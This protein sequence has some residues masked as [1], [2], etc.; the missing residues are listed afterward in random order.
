MSIFLDEAKINIKAGDGGPGIVSF[1]FLKGSHKKIACGGNGGKGGNVVFK[2]SGSVATLYGFKKKVHYKAENG[3]AG[4]PNNRQGKRG[5]DCFINVPAGTVIKNDGEICADLIREGQEYLAEEGGIGGR[6]NASFVSQQRRFPGFAEKG[7]KVC[8]RWINLELRLLADVSIVGFP[9]AGKSTIISRISAA[10]PKI[11]DYPFTTLVPNL[12]VVSVYDDSFVV[13]DIPGLI[14]GAHKGTGLGDRFLRHI[15]RSKLI[16]MVLDCSVLLNSGEVEFLNTFTVLRNELKL[17]GASLHDKP[18]FT[19]INK[20]DLVSEKDTE[21]AELLENVCGKLKK[22][23][24]NDILKTSAATGSG[25]K[26]LV[27]AMYEKIS[28]IRSTEKDSM[29]AHVPPEEELTGSEPSLLAGGY[30][31]YSLDDPA[32]SLSRKLNADKIELIKEGNEFILKNKNIE[33]L[34]SMT[35]LEN[36]E[37]LNYLRDRLKK[38][39]LGEKLKKMGVSEGSTVIINNLVFELVE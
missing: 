7:E 36:E 23:S 19:V 12:G 37:A 29:L 31:V 10:K 27:H 6:G 3:Q 16:V 5:A 25:I 18:F 11:A 15:L 13:A 14:E 22:I 17:Y 39:G 20:T 26:N 8:E 33:R 2:A 30:R 38:M 24:G 1:F 21:A 34:V 9:N 35:D 28:Y 32:I 4:M